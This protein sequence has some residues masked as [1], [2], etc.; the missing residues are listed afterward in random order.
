MRLKAK[1]EVKGDSVLSVKGADKTAAD[2]AEESWQRLQRLL[3]HY[4]NVENGYLS[5]ALPFKEGD[6]EGYYD[7]LARVLEWSAGGDDANGEGGE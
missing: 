1:G 3:S 2:L 6:T 5:R 7:H 4:D